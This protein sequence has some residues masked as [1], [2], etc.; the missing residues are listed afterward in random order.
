[1][2]SPVEVS[3]VGSFERRLL[4]DGVPG[5]FRD[6]VPIDPRN[7]TPQE[8][9]SYSVY[10]ALKALEARENE[11]F[12]PERALLAYGVQRR[13]EASDW[14]HGAWTGAAGEIHMRFT[15]AG[16]RLLVE[17]WCDGL[18]RD[19]AVIVRAIDRHLA[20]AEP[21]ARGRW[22]LHDSFESARAPAPHPFKRL[23]NRAWGSSEE[24]CLVLNTHA[25][26][27]STLMHVLRRVPLALP[28]RE[29]LIAQVLQGIEAL[30]LVLHPSASLASE[31]FATIDSA[32]RA[33]LF[34]SFGTTRFALKA[35]RK[36]IRDIYFPIRQ[37][38]RSHLFGFV[39]QDG[40]LE[41]D[42]SLRG[43]GFE[44]HVVNAYD[45]I[46]VV[47]EAQDEWALPSALQA[48][49]EKL[50]D[51]AI[52][53][54]VNTSYANWL[55]TSMR[56]TTRAVFLCETILARL[57]SMA[58]PAAP[59]TWIEAYCRIRNRLPPTAAILGYDPFMVDGPVESQAPPACDMVRLRNG[60]LL[61]IDLA[62]AT[63]SALPI[64][65]S[66]VRTGKRLAAS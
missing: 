30:E 66:R 47:L 50:V 32:M 41:R 22:F 8:M 18:I 29:W 12:T 55:D 33:R 58:V 6:G 2:T 52:D 46:R 48:R 16:I 17:A 26:T 35:Q 34:A 51:D 56:D 64:T 63:V 21:L 10:L 60:V 14:T 31:V 25:D 11:D 4:P 57:G 36:V 62:S 43:T 38:I 20:Y 37:R 49:C 9:D 5:M 23:A 39:F 13:L 53:Y 65:P 27:L 15:A 59:R 19:P 54:A 3:V 45:L 40:Y 44:Y 42:I 61:K 24:N 7:R 1:M 28:V